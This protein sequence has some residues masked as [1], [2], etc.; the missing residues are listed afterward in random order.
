[1]IAP[2]IAE[3]RRRRME[4]T[5][6]FNGDLHLICEALRRIDAIMG[7]RLVKAAPKRIQRDTKVQPSS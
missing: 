4:H 6:R 1:M 3:V 5:K 2:I 7:D